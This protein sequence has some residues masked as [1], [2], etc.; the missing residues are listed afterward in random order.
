MS[1]R[2]PSPCLLGRNLLIRASSQHRGHRL[3]FLWCHT[4]PICGLHRDLQRHIGAAELRIRRQP[5]G[6]GRRSLLLVCGT[7]DC[8]QIQRIIAETIPLRTIP[9]GSAGTPGILQGHHVVNLDGGAGFGAAYECNL[10]AGIRVFERAGP[11]N[12]ATRYGEAHIMQ[13]PRE[14]I[15]ADVTTVP[16]IVGLAIPEFVALVPLAGLPGIH[17]ERAQHIG[18]R[19]RRYVFSGDSRCRRTHVRQ[20]QTDRKTEAR[21]HNDDNQA[22]RPRTRETRATEAPR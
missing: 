17:H 6:R 7:I 15:V 11:H 21:D 10:S 1:P 16:V 14:N 2:L 9:L 4:Q 18:D 13:V 3:T 20:S 22:S 8:Q 5:I 12:A 19:A